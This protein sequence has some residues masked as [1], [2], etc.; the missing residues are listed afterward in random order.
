[1]GLLRRLLGAP[2]CKFWCGPGAT[3]KWAAGRHDH[4]EACAEC[5]VRQQRER[6]YLERLRGAAVPAASEDLTAR[7]LARTGELAAG[8]EDAGQTQSAPP[9]AAPAAVTGPG[10][11][12][13]AVPGPGRAP[14]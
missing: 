6:Q 1:M 4:V 8:P 10:T 7:L 9:D 2:G 14:Q 3:R 5:R 13:G 11:I 12:P